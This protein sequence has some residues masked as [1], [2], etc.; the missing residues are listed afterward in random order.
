LAEKNENNSMSTM[1]ISVTEQIERILDEARSIWRFKWTAMGV[2]WLVAVLGWSFVY[3]IPDVFEA[4]A[5]VFVDT[6]TALRPLL[7]GLAI[8]SAVQPQLDLVRQALLSRPHLEKVAAETDLMLRATT[9]AEREALIQRLQTEIT[10]QR[11]NDNLYTLTYQDTSREMSVEVVQRLLASFIEDVL[12]IKQEGQETAQRFLQ[13]R[14]LDYERRLSEA[15]ARLAD[16]KKKNLGL[17]PGERGDY[18]SRLQ[19][20]EEALNQGKSQL[21]VAERRRDQLQRQLRG[22]TEFATARAGSGPPMSGSNAGLIAETEA[23]LQELLLKYTDRHPEVQALRETID[24]L[25]ERQAADL[26]NLR[27]GIVGTEVSNNPVYQEIQVGLNEVDVEIAAIRGEIAEREQRIFDLR[28]L[29]DTAPEVEAEFA[30]LNRDYGVTRTQYDSLVQRLETARLSEQADQTG[31]INFEIIDPPVA[32]V[33]PVAPDRPMLLSAI[34]VV[35]LIG[36]AGV[37]FARHIGQPV[38]L[39]PRRLATETGLQVLGVIG[40]AFPE[41][42]RAERMR[43]LIGVAVATTALAGVYVLAL[44]FLE[45]LTALA[46]QFVGA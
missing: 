20:E 29:L 17:V 4:R 1:T 23:R 8:D 34:L 11:G 38:F 33:Q 24:Q 42:R 5:R 28:Q 32:S 21:A 22:E 41:R 2:A 18:F 25:R 10:F 43:G 6:S 27:D 30:R 40:S 46:Q 7:Q 16:F 44:I 35:A 45:P 9:E 13:E 12:G 19:N 14:I 26:V 39:N 3:T 37:A 36:G 15:E 31:V